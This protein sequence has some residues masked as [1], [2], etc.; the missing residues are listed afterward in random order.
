MTTQ[1]MCFCVKTLEYLSERG[2]TL[3]CKCGTKG[4]GKQRVCIHG[5][6]ELIKLAVET[7]EAWK[8]CI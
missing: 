2:V 7:A 6:F 8:S 1:L 5:V 4:R 3:R